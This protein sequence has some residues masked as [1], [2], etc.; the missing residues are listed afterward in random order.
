MG[1]R[2]VRGMCKSLFFITLVVRFVACEDYVLRFRCWY[3]YYYYRSSCCCLNA[4]KRG[5]M[6]LPWLLNLRCCRQSISN[7]HYYYYYFQRAASAFA[8]ILAMPLFAGIGTIVLSSCCCCV[9][10]VSASSSVSLRIFAKLRRY[11]TTW[12]WQSSFQSCLGS[13]PSWRRSRTFRIF[14]HRNTCVT[15]VPLRPYGFASHNGHD[16]SVFGKWP[17]SNGH[18]PHRAR[19]SRI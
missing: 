12:N 19:N 6:S 11:M 7:Y 17:P 10:C 14:S 18:A 5:G 13:V 1:T 3:Y 2:C 15:A 8:M 16:S 9:C 4:I